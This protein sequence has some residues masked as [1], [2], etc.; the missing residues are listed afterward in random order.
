M[1][2]DIRNWRQSTRFNWFIILWISAILVV[3]FLYYNWHIDLNYIGIVQQ[4]SHT[5]GPQEAGKVNSVMV[6][7]GDLVAKDQ[8]LAVMEMPDLNRSLT[9]LR[10]ELGTIQ[11]VYS[12]EESMQ[13]AAAQTLRLQTE[14][15][16]L[17]LIEK[18]SV[19]ESKSA[20]LNSLNAEIKRLENAEM[21]GLGYSRDLSALI[22]QRDAAE[23]YLR[24]QRLEFDRL[25]KRVEAIRE[26]R[27]HFE[28]AGFDSLTQLLMLEHLEYAESI[29]QQIILTEHRIQMRTIVSPCDGYVTEI[30][31][32]AGDIV[33]DFDS[34]L[35]VEEIQPEFLTVYLPEKTKVMP[36]PGT[37]VRIFSSR[38]REYNTTGTV[39][40]VHPGFTKADER[41]SFRG[42]RFWARRVRVKLSPDHSLLPGEVVTTRMNNHVSMFREENDQA[43]PPDM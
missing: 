39:T 22:I 10:D 12:S 2:F 3:A 19:I 9:H 13:N 5:L 29:R 17:D 38:D 18:L 30:V 28:N 43:S 40:F 4:K 33:Q 7:V 42:L 15:E 35:V 37:E 23:A 1:G 31:A 34:L 8:V 26:S 20:E 6:Q 27:A 14:N 41:L 21:A 16:I 24:A 25:T 32:N 11:K 36:E